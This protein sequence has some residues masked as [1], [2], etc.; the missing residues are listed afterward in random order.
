M[1]PNLHAL[2]ELRGQFSACERTAYLMA[3][4][5]SPICRDARDA[6]IERSTAMADEGGLRFEEGF[7]L[8]ED[9][10]AAFA[11]LIGAPAQRVAIV[12][13]A[14]LAYNLLASELRDQFSSVTLQG[15]EFPSATLPWLSW[16]Y[17]LH[18]VKASQW[19]GT[20]EPDRT[21]LV[22]LPWVHFAHGRRVADAAL[23]R[24]LASSDRYVI[25]NG[26]QGL[27]CIPFSVQT[28][29]VDALICT[30]HKW[31]FG[32]EGVCFMYLSE[33]LAAR[34]ARRFVGWRSVLNPMAMS[35]SPSDLQPLPRQYELGLSSSISAAATLAGL[36]LLSRIG[37]API[38]Q[39]V[40][41]L[42]QRLLEQLAERQIAVDSP[43]D[44]HQGSGIV[45]IRSPQPLA[46][47]DHLRGHGVLTTARAGGLRVALHGYNN[48]DDL[49]RLLSALQ[50]APALLSV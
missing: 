1:T 49:A 19:E 22:S 24:L 35:S 36:R 50:A 31:L 46:L 17:E 5:V 10:R 16:G 33:R 45:L 9:C 11:A 4:A 14:S 12:G 48:D 13:S 32:H 44:A 47:R 37:V 25:V 2:P 6:I 40:Q 3:A 15:D 39:Q 34:L 43:A 7:Q 20:S 27:G 18:S 38:W 29:P 26:T 28:T 21:G 42:R 23:Q 8:W 30:S 41:G